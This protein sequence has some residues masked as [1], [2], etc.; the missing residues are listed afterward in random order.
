MWCYGGAT[1]SIVASQL[2]DPG[3]EL[4]SVW[5]ITCSPSLRGFSWFPPTS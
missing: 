4:L 3:L 2:Q 5:S 1:G